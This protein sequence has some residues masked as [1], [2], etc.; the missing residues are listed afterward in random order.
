M[1]ILENKYPM[2]SFPSQKTPGRYIDG[3]LLENHRIMA[4]NITNDMTFLTFIFSSTLEVGTGKSVLASQ[5]GEAWTYL[6]KEIHGIEVPFDMNNC[7]FKPQDLIQRS[8]KV[9]KYSF[10]WLDEWEDAHF[11]SQL[12]MSLRQ[13]FRKCRQLNLY[14]VC[15]IPNFFQLPIGYAVS[16]SVAAIDVQFKGE[17]ERGYFRFFNFERKKLLYIKGKKTQ[18]YNC[19]APNFYGR[20]VNGYA[21]DQTEY[22]RL[23]LKD[24]MDSEKQEK[25]LPTEFEIRRRTFRQVRDGLKNKLSVLELAKAFGIGKTTA[26]RWLSDDVTDNDLENEGSSPDVPSNIKELTNS[27]DKSEE[28][29]EERDINI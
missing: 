13:F 8:F 19:V 29:T 26:W 3:N 4:K 17:F 21:V 7:V 14:I 6:M 20:F 23:K 1:K 16:R 12:G 2:G 5:L 15:I 10:I 22:R 11:M 18:D 24:M 27:S 28:I 25:K 9:P